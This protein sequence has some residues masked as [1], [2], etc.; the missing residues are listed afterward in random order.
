MIKQKEILTTIQQLKDKY[1]IHA[2]DE[3]IMK[4]LVQTLNQ[5]ADVYYQTGSELMTNFEY[6]ELYDKL[7]ELEAKTGI[8]LPDS[9]TQ[10]VGSEINQTLAKVTH[11]YPALSLDKTKDITLFPK[12]FHIRDEQTVVMWKEDGSTLVA[13][14]DDGK[15]TKLA[16]RGNGKIGQD[17]TH[18]AQYIKGLP[19][20]I[21]INGHAVFRGEALMS[22]EEFKRVNE[23]LP[24]KEEHYKN[25]R[26]LANA[27][28]QLSA[29]KQL[30]HR[31]IWFHAFKL[32]HTDTPASDRTFE[33]DMKF[34][35]TM[36]FTVTKHELC[37]TKDVISIMNKFSNQVASYPFPVDGLVVAANDVIYAETQPGTSNHPNR[38]VGFALKW[39][40]ET[41]TTTLRDIEWSPSRTGL[42]NPVAIFDPVELE[43]TTVTRASVHNV[44]IIKKLHLR[45]GDKINVFKANKIIPQ[46]AENLTAG[47]P[48][49]DIEAKPNVCPCCGKPTEIIQTNN[50]GQIVEIAVCPNQDC[51]AKHIGKFTHFCERDCMNITGLSEATITKF[52]EKGWIQEFADIYHLNKHKDEIVNTD[53]FGSKSYEN[54]IKA[55]ETSRKTSFIPF[56][57]ALGIPNIGE[58]QAKLFAKAYNSD[59]PAFFHDIAAHKD[60]THIDGIGPVLNNSLHTWGNTYLSYLLSSEPDTSTT[61]DKEIC[62]LIQELTFDIPEAQNINEQTLTGITFVITGDVH[63]FKNRNEMKTEIEKRGGK[64]SSSVSSK[65]N[66]LINNNITSTSGKNKKAKDLGIPIISEDDFIKML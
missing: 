30:E 64:V 27:T 4:N 20:T 6:D 55:I 65:T 2:I 7:V 44:S 34:M 31:E 43:G 15:L 32:V 8:I 25:P 24:E 28:V 63:H 11:E 45:I 23:S 53:G 3:A 22:Y 1:G 60:F 13:T 21:P 9:P 35:E 59:I 58:G 61:N 38:L 48:L 51:A 19:M 49:T 16:T 42:L 29:K 18:N 10:K 14:Y 54:L 41:I 46:I 33:K 62:N 52:V 50:N 47:Q 12:V 5:A 37:C 36:G 17:I 57:H 66:Y 39:E 40:D 26:N 56:I